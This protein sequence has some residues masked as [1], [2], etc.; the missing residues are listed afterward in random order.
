MPLKPSIVNVFHIF[1]ASPSDM[2][3]ERAVVREFFTEY[4]RNIAAA[5]GIRFE[6]VDYENYASIGVGRPQELITK[7]TLEKHRDS[8]ALVIGLMGQRFG[9]PT[10]VAESGAEEEFNWAL[11]NHRKTGFPEIKWFFRQVTNFVAPPEPDK[12]Q[13]ATEQWTKVLAFRRRLREESP[14]VFYKEFR[15]THDFR[16][17]L[18]NDLSLWLIDS[19]RPWCMKAGEPKTSLLE[20]PTVAPPHLYYKSLFEE[21]RWLDISGIDNERV[22]NIPLSDMYVK[23]RVILDKDTRGVL[24]PS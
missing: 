23:L 20:E 10:G 24:Y 15:E 2:K 7:Q 18:R 4:N 16:D 9:V 3:D 1:I 12:I 19:E 6:V 8:L 5:S 21:F 11:E 22:F 17:I 13:E 14:P